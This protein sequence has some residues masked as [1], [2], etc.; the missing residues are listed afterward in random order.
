MNEIKNHTPSPAIDDLAAERDQLA[1]MLARARDLLRGIEIEMWGG[2]DHAGDL[3]AQADRLL[4]PLTAEHGR[5]DDSTS[6]ERVAWRNPDGE[7]VAAYGFDEFEYNN[8]DELAAEVRERADGPEQSQEMSYFGDR[9]MVS[10]HDHS[11]GTVYFHGR[12]DAAYSA[13]AEPG[14]TSNLELAVWALLEA[15]RE[16]QV[17]R[18]DPES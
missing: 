6:D 10:V 15:A 8:F 5:Y 7:I 1:Q 13:F 3:R 9:S 4:I 16:R 11:A 14:S 12:L 17:L 2:P 18:S